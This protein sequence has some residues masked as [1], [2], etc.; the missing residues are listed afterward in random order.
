MG[1]QFPNGK[2]SSKIASQTIWQPWQPDF[3]SR[4]SGQF[5]GSGRHVGQ[6]SSA[7]A[8]H[9]AAIVWERGTAPLP[10]GRGAEW[11]ALLARLGRAVRN[12]RIPRLSEAGISGASVHLDR[13]GD[14]P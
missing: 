4:Q 3:V 14:A 9:R 11:Q 7:S 5:K 13:P 10:D 12:G 6:L 2:F 1:K 8:F